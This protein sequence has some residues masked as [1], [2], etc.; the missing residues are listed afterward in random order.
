MEPTAGGSMTVLINQQDRDI[1]QTT[2]LIMDQ[3][4]LLGLAIL[5]AP[6]LVAAMGLSALEAVEEIEETRDNNRKKNKN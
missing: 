2:D 5:L 3:G 6:P 1:T 4:L